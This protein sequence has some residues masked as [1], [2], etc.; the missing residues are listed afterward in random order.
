MKNVD[1]AKIGDRVVLNSDRISV[2][3]AVDRHAQGLNRSTARS[4]DVARGRRTHLSQSTARSTRSTD[5]SSK[6]G[7]D[8]DIERSTDS[9]VR[10]DFG[11]DLELF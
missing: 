3:W 10:I 8:R 9:R 1:R 4:T 11:P 5:I 6:S 7:N 2:D